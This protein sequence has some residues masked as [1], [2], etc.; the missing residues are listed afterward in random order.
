MAKDS[1]S[2]IKG[3]EGIGLWVDYVESLVVGYGLEEAWEDLGWGKGDGSLRS[4]RVC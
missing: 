1:G 2:G 4:K 3:T